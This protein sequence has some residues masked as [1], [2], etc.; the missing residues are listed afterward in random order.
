MLICCGSLFAQVKRT[1]TGTV[2]DA[3]GKPVPGATIT[4]KGTV[5]AVS[6]D[7]NGHYSI[8]A[9]DNAVLEVSSIGY[10]NQDMKVGTNT[11][12][13][14]TLTT[15]GG[16][17]EGEVVVTALGIKRE[18]KS[19]GYAVQ[20]VKGQAL[21]EA[22]EPNLVNDLTGK[23]AGLQVVRSG[24]GI[25]GSSQIVLRGNNSLTGLSQPL[26]VIDGIPMSNAI[27]RV[28]G[29]NDFW[30][31]TLDM[32][33]GLS[34]IN[35]DDI[36]SISVLKGPA[37]AGLYGSLGGNGVILITTK[38]GKKQQGLGITVSSSVGFSSIFTNPEIQSAYGQ[39]S[40]GLF[41]A[42]SDL[43]WGPKIEG[44]SYT[45]WAGVNRS[46]QA[47]NNVKNYFQTGIASNQNVSF[48]QQLGGTSV[49]TSYN[50]MDNKDIVPGSKLVRNNIT[51]RAITKFGR[52][53]KWTLDTKVQFINATADN[54]PLVGQNVNNAFAI[55]YNLPRSLDITSF[56]HSVDS[57]GNMI[58]YQPGNNMNPYWS[59]QYN[60]N[61]DTRNRFLLNGTLK[62]QFTDWLSAE[63]SGGA[64]MYTTNTESK[65]Y[66]GSPGNV[67]GSYGLGK[68]TYRQTN[69]STMFTAKKDN[70]FGK[71]GG[72][73]MV[74]GNLMAWENS[75]LS[76]SAASLKVPNL[77]SV[78]NSKGNPSITQDY[79][80]KKINSAYGSVELNYDGYLFLNGTF[81][82][83]WSSTLS[84]LN[85][86][87]FYPSVGL[88]YVITD[89]ITRNGGALPGWLSFAKLRGTYA[90]AG[91]DLDP[92]QL[93]N[94]YFIGNDPNSNTIA[95]RNTTLFNDSVK[96]QL[97]KSLEAGLEMR[98]FQ[99]RFG[100]DLS[101]YKT[102]TTN[103]LIDL[104]MDPLSGYNYR[105]INAGNVQNA[106][107]ELIADAK[108]LTHQNS[109]NW[110][111]S[112]NYSHNNN[113]VKS[114]YP[115]VPKYQL[116][117]GSFDDIQILAVEGQKYGEIYGTQFARV[118]DNT[119][120]S[121]GQLLLSSEGLPQ[122][123][124]DGDRVR[125]GNQQAS[126]LLG[127]TNS[128][129]YKN[130]G[131]SFQVDARFG[132]KIFSGT[133]AAMER[134]GT[135]GMT[136][137]NGSRDSVIVNGVILNK[138]TNEYEPNTK[139]VSA[140]QYWGAM[141]GEG[142]IGITEANLYDASNI[143]IRNIQLSYNFPKKMLSGS[144]I[145]RAAVSVSC[146]NVWLISSHMHGIDPESVYATGTPAV[147]FEN[148]SA[149][150]SR[151]FFINFTLG[152]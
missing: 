15:T 3:D 21:V 97:M 71:L 135:A 127:V 22:R 69:F 123:A 75:S 65:L 116:P 126:G 51:T 102:N 118:T 50:R 93:Y 52:Q 111:I 8:Q 103:Q 77:F 41:N 37:A 70:L 124:N 49:Y 28:N 81:R 14:I 43:S 125:L 44:Q 85:R 120:S 146:N 91:S 40:N 13:D 130:F 83:D 66:A 62:H 117:G 119:S 18:R 54:R 108:I 148:G 72:S 30:N 10:A 24:N 122:V 143:R 82:N 134:S 90:Q 115:G 86:S 23:V 20:E 57:A 131:L 133:L 4:I 1:I 89:M 88:S 63:V 95:W 29:N 47:Y 46:M 11:T 27:G 59:R 109:L 48:Q 67:T 145:Q 99:S 144:F 141:A 33:N 7:E 78:T 84:K 137:V 138:T 55:A 64:D 107:V 106:G 34:D 12:V 139:K 61:S 38:S 35:A 56:K 121:Y 74:G 39:G 45:D 73:I 60:L 114:I 76:A 31:P 9:T 17:T 19:L 98:F 94:T 5:T 87:F 152:F 150:T 80:Q 151:T 147:G 36:E 104:P 128:F 100:I 2:T 149:P 110:N 140:Q 112:V 25:G 32:G 68:Q 113:V 142:N 105:K 132:G 96:A 92:Y 136:V 6:T 58:W 53:E 101:F 129:A 42:T 26:I 16:K 79:S